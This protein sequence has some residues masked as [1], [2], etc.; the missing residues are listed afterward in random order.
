MVAWPPPPIGVVQ[1]RAGA[2]ETGV[3]TASS[4]PLR[5]A[6]EF[7][8]PSHTPIPAHTS[9]AAI[10]NGDTTSPSALIATGV[11]VPTTSPPRYT[12]VSMNVLD[13][14]RAS[15]PTAV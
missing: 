11:H 12:K 8:T 9:A 4:S 15:E 2:D 13:L 14:Y 6:R 3:P 10:A 1:S 5:R 7:S